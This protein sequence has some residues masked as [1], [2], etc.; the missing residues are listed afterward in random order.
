MIK[1]WLHGQMEKQA[2][3]AYSAWAKEK[4]NDG[5]IVSKWESI[6]EKERLVWCKVADAIA[7]ENSEDSQILAKLIA[8]RNRITALEIEL[9]E[10]KELYGVDQQKR[11]SWEGGKQ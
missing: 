9:K 1:C 8:A 10:I 6:S 11:Q 3:I 5:K 4:E 7:S 2:K